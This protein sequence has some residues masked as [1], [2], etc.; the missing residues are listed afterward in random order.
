[1]DPVAVAGEDASAPV[2][3]DI[4][5]EEA[6]AG[7]GTGEAEDGPAGETIWDWAKD[8]FGKAW[9]WTTGKAEEAWD[10]IKGGAGDAAAAAAAGVGGS[11]EA[12]RE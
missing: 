1:M 2:G 3:I 4:P 11:D 12:Q 5:D 6:P 9:T 10:K 7:A 8:N